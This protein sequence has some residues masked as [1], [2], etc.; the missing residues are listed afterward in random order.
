MDGALSRGVAVV[1]GAHEAV[2]P[3]GG[4]CFTVLSVKRRW[5]PH[6]HI[7]RRG[8][9]AAAAPARDHLVKPVAEYGVDVLGAARAVRWMEAV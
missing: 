7:A 9:A 2:A 6:T 3:C 8:G 1:C 5:Q 4:S